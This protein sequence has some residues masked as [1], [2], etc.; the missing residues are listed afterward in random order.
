MEI[1]FLKIS[2]LN[3]PFSVCGINCI[4]QEHV[5]HLNHLLLQTLKEKKRKTLGI[6]KQTEKKKIYSQTLL[7]TC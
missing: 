2:C 4:Q 1:I 3:K 6:L 5:F 7:E